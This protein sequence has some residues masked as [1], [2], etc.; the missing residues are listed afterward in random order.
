MSGLYDFKVASQIAA[1]DPPFD[2]L[3][4]AA[5][6]KADDGNLG[7]LRDA[8][9]TLVAETTARY[10]APGGRLPSDGPVPS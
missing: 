9:P 10:H 4:M 8:F 2:A 6:I 7:R 1:T 3:I 5:V